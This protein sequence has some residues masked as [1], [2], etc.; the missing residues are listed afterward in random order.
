MV[1]DT[2][3]WLLPVQVGLQLLAVGRLVGWAVVHLR[4]QCSH[5]VVCTYRCT[6][7]VR[8]T[9]NLGIKDDF[10]NQTAGGFHKIDWDKGEMR[11]GGSMVARLT[12][13][14]S[15]GFESGI[16]PAHGK[17]GQSLGGLASGM[18]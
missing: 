9:S 17:L 13:S 10:L 3:V 7:H 14:S 4:I 5:L 16:Y 6:L 15:P 2:L 18:T 1:V 12:A 8:H 11:R